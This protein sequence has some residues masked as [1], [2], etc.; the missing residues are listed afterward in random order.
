MNQELSYNTK[1]LYKWIFNV[2]QNTYKWM[3][4]LILHPNLKMYKWLSSLN[5]GR[6]SKVSRAKKQKVSAKVEK[7]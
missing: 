3:S 5:K 6:I 1:I 4:E 7:P 2:H